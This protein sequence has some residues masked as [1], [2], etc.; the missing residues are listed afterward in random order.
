MLKPASQN[1]QQSAMDSSHPRGEANG[2]SS[3]T[4]LILGVRQMVTHQTEVR[5]RPESSLYFIFQLSLFRLKIFFFKLEN[6]LKILTFAF[7]TF[8]YQLQ[9]E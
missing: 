4:L 7:E 5:V 9:K 6:P 3:W 2:D 1:N 8:L